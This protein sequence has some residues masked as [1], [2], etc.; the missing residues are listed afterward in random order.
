MNY[1]MFS[2]A[3]NRVCDTL[4]NRVNKGITNGKIKNRESAVKKINDGIAKIAKHHDE[5]HDSEP[6]SHIGYGT[7]RAFKNAGWERYD[8]YNDRA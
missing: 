4:V 6:P 8:R 3:G 1:E 7:E 2:A 5:V